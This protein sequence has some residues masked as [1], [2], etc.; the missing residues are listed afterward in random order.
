MKLIISILKSEHSILDARNMKVLKP[1]KKQMYVTNEMLN[2]LK[3]G[4]HPLLFRYYAKRGLYVFKMNKDFKKKYVIV[5]DIGID[6]S[7]PAQFYAVLI[8]K[9]YAK[10][11][12]GKINKNFEKILTEITGMELIS[13]KI[14]S[15]NME[16]MKIQ[17]KYLETAKNDIVVCSLDINGINIYP[18]ID[19]FFLN[20]TKVI[21]LYGINPKLSVVDDEKNLENTFFITYETW[22]KSF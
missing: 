1:L 2:K 10:L 18:I 8:S 22:K 9:A 17:E 14:S 4:V 20:D 16:E 6:K 19:C 15:D 13:T 21:R 5:D 7:D 11:Y 3:E 12:R